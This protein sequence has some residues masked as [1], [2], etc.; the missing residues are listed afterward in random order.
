[1]IE[2]DRI[3]AIVTDI[4][5]TTSSISF[6]HDV[7]F[8]YARQKLPDYV[9]THESE[10]VDILNQVREIEKNPSLDTEQ[11]I[12][13][14]TLWIDEDRKITPLKTLQGLIWEAGFKSG[15]FKGHI[16]EDA[17][18][19]LQEWYDRGFKLYVYSSGS[20]GAQKLLY[21]YSECGDLTPLLSGYFDTTTGPKREAVSYKKI[22]A[23]VGF[24]PAQ[25]L[26]LSDITEELDAAKEAGF[27]TVLLDRD[28]A[29]PENIPY[30]RAPDFS[31]IQI[32]GSAA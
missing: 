19:A 24:L 15:A 25:I 3:K 26:F 20:I 18:E 11:I 32:R 12:S 30:N 31:H 16:Y 7:L 5:G 9:R 8:P 23:A 10:I 6:V 13:I 27:Q 4:E 1:M 21:G 29:Q 17:A 28:K 22:A 2:I 14:F